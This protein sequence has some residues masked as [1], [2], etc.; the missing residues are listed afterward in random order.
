MTS[1]MTA[2]TTA[3]SFNFFEMFMAGFYSLRT[4]TASGCTAISPF[5]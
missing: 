1:V 2:G 4:R 3:A 5:V